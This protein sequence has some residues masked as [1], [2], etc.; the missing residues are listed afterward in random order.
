MS[1]M[2]CDGNRVFLLKVI[3]RLAKLS[4]RCIW[5]PWSNSGWRVRVCMADGEC[6]CF[7][8]DRCPRELHNTSYEI[9]Q[10]VM[11]SE[12]VLAVWVGS[13]E[14]CIDECRKEWEDALL[15]RAILPTCLI[16]KEYNIGKVPSNMVI[17]ELVG[18][19]RRELA[20]KKTFTFYNLH[21]ELGLV[22]ETI[23][24]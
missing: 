17:K 10:E 18:S 8:M 1:T 9:A 24:I 12:H 16:D 11:N 23:T 2:C 21:R 5:D 7:E 14:Y 6:S 20:E 22:V 19:M 4:E 15:V 13:D 3:G